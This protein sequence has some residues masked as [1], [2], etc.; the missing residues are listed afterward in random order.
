MWEREEGEIKLKTKLEAPQKGFGLAIDISSDGTKIAIGQD[1]GSV[2]IFDVSKGNVTFSIPGL[3]QPIRTVKFSP[4]TH[5]LA[6]AG[7][8]K[9][10]SLY[11]V[12]SNEHVS[13]FKGHDGWIFSL[14][15]SSTGEYLLSG[16]YDGKV[17]V[18]SMETM[19]IGNTQTENSS[20]ILCVAWLEKGWGQ[21]VIGGKNKGFVTVGEDKAI[22]WYR[23]A[24][25]A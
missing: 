20:P 14:A 23:E 16:S 8:A 9:F 13:D 3:S 7:D 15:W 5:Y 18:W 25:G 1:N 22:R 6:V 2:D 24:G 19:S 4:G 10:I 12:V 17:K 21:G 11:N